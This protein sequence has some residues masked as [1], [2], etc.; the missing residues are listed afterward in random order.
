MCVH[1]GYY[2]S[3]INVMHLTEFVRA[4]FCN[5][6]LHHYVLF[7][8]AQL[9]ISE[10]SW[11]LFP[12]CWNWQIYHTHQAFKLPLCTFNS[13]LRT[14]PMVKSKTIGFLL[15]WTQQYTPVLFWQILHELLPE[16]ELLSS[17]YSQ[18]ADTCYPTRC[19]WLHN[20]HFENCLKRLAQWLLVLQMC[21][22]HNA[23]VERGK[24]KTEHCY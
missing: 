22:S 5:L 3:I 18:V 7:N 16:K 8:L 19:T 10:K 4:K 20:V 23:L 24:D 15:D 2:I 12:K 11:Y 9:F 13:K 14:F 21:I 17:H 6:F 1:W